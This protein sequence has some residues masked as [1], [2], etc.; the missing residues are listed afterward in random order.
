[1]SRADP[2]YDLPA[3]QAFL[4]SLKALIA[5]DGLLLVLRH[6]DGTW[7]LPGGLLEIGEPLQDGL[8]RE[9]SEETGLT[10]EVGPLLIAWDHWVHGFCFRD[11]RV[12]DV[13]AVLLAYVCT[14]TSEQI[15]LSKEHNAYAWASDT[16]LKELHFSAGCQAAVDSYLAHVAGE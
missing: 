7:D 4:V 1:M 8:L 14:A 9:V 13:R 3:G 11:G 5:D 16:D 10:V 15:Q 12:A 6:A 2:H